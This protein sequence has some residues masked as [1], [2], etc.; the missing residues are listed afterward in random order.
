MHPFHSLDDDPAVPFEVFTTDGVLQMV[1]AE[2][3]AIFD[4]ADNHIYTT[5]TSFDLHG[6]SYSGSI[7]CESMGISYYAS[8]S[9][10]QSCLDKNDLFI[11]LDPYHPQYN[12][13]FLNIYTAKSLTSRSYNDY[14]ENLNSTYFPLEKLKIPSKYFNL[15]SNYK[16]NVITTDMATNWAQQSEGEGA[17][18]VSIFRIFKFTPSADSS[19]RVVSE[20]ANRG[21]CNTFEGIC[22]CFDGFTGGACE[23]QDTVF[24]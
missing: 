3:E 11:F 22:D 6:G 7:S 20:C 5:N 23:E 13:P 16:R 17:A 10:K 15:S 1:S 21:I 19:Y 8:P 24:N 12:P 4:F 9:E 14:N 2:A 18:G